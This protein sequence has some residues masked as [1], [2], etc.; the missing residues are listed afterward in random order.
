MDYFGRLMRWLGIKNRQATVLCV[1]LDNSGKST[2]INHFK[3]PQTK[4]EEL[5]PTIGYSI[6][7]F[8][9]SRITF[10]VFDMSGQ[11]RYRSLW[12]QYYN[13][14][15][16]IIFVIDS[17]DKIRLEVAKDELHTLLEH[18]DIKSKRI[19]ICCLANKKDLKDALSDVEIADKLDLIEIS[20]KPYNIL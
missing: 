7:K 19:P 15:Q 17:S 20:N 3:P 6:E 10:T 2:V 18:D 8:A 9:A 11:G 4:S 16:A 13:E 14:A 1:G 5:V 12:E